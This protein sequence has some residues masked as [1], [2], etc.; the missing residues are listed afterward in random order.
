MKGTNMTEMFNI[1]T[2]DE[3][4]KMKMEEDVKILRDVFNNYIIPE[5]KRRGSSLEYQV[6]APVPND[7]EQEVIDELRAKQWYARVTGYHS[8]VDRTGSREE[9]PIFYIC[10]LSQH[11]TQPEK[12][13]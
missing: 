6:K 2:P 1:P 8:F 5:L 3:L 12:N 10:P 9:W 4:T 11:A 13:E 7:L